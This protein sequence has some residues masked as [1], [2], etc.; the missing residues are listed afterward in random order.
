VAT[1]TIGLSWDRCWKTLG[2]V[3]IAIVLLLVMV[4]DLSVGFFV[5]Q[6]G[7]NPFRFLNDAGLPE[8]TQTYGRENLS[9]T[10]WFFLLLALLFLLAVNTFVCTTLRV[11][12]LVRSR[13]AFPSRVRFAMKLSPHVMHYALIVILLGYLS[14]YLFAQVV[15]NNPL[16]VGKSVPMRPTQYSA[17]LASLEIDTSQS[18]RLGAW[19]KRALDA[20]AEIHFLDDMGEVIRKGEVSTNNPLVFRGYSVHLKDFGPRSRM[21]GM[22]RQPFVNLIIKKDPGIVLYFTGT[23]LFAAGLGMYLGDWLWTRA[24]KGE[25][26]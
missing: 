24:K 5:L 8:W 1:M 3:E 9:E 15:P 10:L 4:V 7:A 26:S 23:L 22:S 25:P 11:S 14:S 12:A 13:S 20:R 19:R 16:T 6:F 21:G 18:V 17:K 2:S